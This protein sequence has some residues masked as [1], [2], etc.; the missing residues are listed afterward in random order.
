MDKMKGVAKM[1]FGNFFADRNKL[2]IFCGTR[3]EYSPSTGCA[4][5]CTAIFNC[6]LCIYLYRVFV[7]LEVASRVTP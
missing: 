6:P 1:R 4:H 5:Y 3:V 7:A 2:L